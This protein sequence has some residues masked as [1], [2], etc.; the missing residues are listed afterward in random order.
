MKTY[1]FS[2]NEAENW[3]NKKITSLMICDKLYWLQEGHCYDSHI[4]GED[5]A[6][7]IVLDELGL[8]EV[9]ESIFETDLTPEVV[10]EKLLKYP[11]FEFDE[12]FQE[13]IDGYND[14]N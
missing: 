12:K 9:S 10:K 11:N 14:L 5:E 1:V 6:L 8:E 13:L 3:N 7:D 2:V 4:S